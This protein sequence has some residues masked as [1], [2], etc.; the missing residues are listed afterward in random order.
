MI[1]LRKADVE[2][3]KIVAGMGVVGF[4]DD[5]RWWVGGILLDQVGDFGCGG[6]IPDSIA[7][8]E[9]GS[10][11]RDW[12]FCDLG[13]VGDAAAIGSLEAMVAEGAADREVSANAGL[14]DEAASF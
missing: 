1:I 14:K 7:G 5:R 13:G 8:N 12:G 4:G 3:G 2:G 11:G 6:Y 9:K 10:V